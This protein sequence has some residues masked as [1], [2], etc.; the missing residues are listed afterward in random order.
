MKVRHPRTIIG[1][2]KDNSKCYLIVVDGRRYYSIGMDVWEMTRLVKQ[3]NIYNAMNLDGGG[4]S[5]MAMGN[6]IFNSPSDGK[7]RPVANA[8]MVISTEK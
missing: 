5:V 2:S 6:Y 3:L 8:L 7:E 1:F 4:S